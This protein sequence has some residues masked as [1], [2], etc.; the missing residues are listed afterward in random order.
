MEIF[1][2]DLGVL[3]VEVSWGTD[4][5]MNTFERQT[6]TPFYEVFDR[7]WS[8]TAAKLARPYVKWQIPVWGILRRHQTTFQMPTIGW[9]THAYTTQYTNSLWSLFFSSQLLTIIT[10]HRGKA[11]DSND[12]P[13][14]IK[15]PVSSRIKWWLCHLILLKINMNLDIQ[16]KYSMECVRFLFTRHTLLWCHWGRRHRWGQCH[17]DLIQARY[18]C[19]LWRKN[20]WKYKKCKYLSIRF[21]SL[22]NCFT[23]KPQPSS[24]WNPA[25]CRS[26]YTASYWSW[27]PWTCFGCDFRKLSTLPK[28]NW[29]HLFT[30]S[31]LLD[32]P[33]MP[34][35]LDTE[36][37]LFLICCPMSPIAKERSIRP[38]ID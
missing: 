7:V 33:P 36:A 23:C 28:F 8:V 27:S 32:P 16:V 30:I 29:A 24:C 11:T 9:L 20:W 34:S 6:F 1:C 18:R 3:G 22:P 5:V 31:S 37:T 21:S 10:F 25:H 19:R 13:I 38:E 35:A 15:I 4:E 26:C 12:S 17:P 14:D 2:S